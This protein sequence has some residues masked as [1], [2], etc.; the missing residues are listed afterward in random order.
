MAKTLADLPTGRQLAPRNALIKLVISGDLRRITV[1][2]QG[3]AARGLRLGADVRQ[4]VADL[5]AIGD[6]CD[7]I[8][9]ASALRTQQQKNLVDPRNQ[10]RPQV[11]RR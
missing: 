1:L 8:H 2:P 9:L 3:R 6:K 11:A 4:Y 10:R 5:R 7:Q